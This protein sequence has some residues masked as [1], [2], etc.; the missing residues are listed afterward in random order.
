M[1][2]LIAAAGTGGHVY[3]G[4]AVGE[5]LLDLGIAQSEILYVGGDRMEATVYPEAG[6]P[7]LRVEMRGLQRSASTR[8]LSLPRVVWRARD[9]IAGAMT[10]RKV[11][12]ALALGG[13]ITV[14]TGLAAR[15][16]HLPLMV[17]EQ[18]AEAGLANRVV[19]RWAVRS[20]ASFPNTPG[21]SRAEWVGN[22][23][24]LSIAEFDRIELR[25][26]A[27]AY[28][29]LAPD[30]PTLGVFGGSLGAGA[31]N[32]AVVAMCDAWAGPPLQIVHVT[33]P[34]NL[35]GLVAR[36]SQADVRWLRIGFED[37]ME[38]F[39]AAADL[40]V[41]RAGGGIAELTATGTPAILVPGEFGARGHQA[42]NANFLTGSGAAVLL[43][44]ANLAAL[45]E[46]VASIIFDPGVISEMSEAARKIGRPDAARV[47][48]AAMVEVAA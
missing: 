31:I 12:V 25:P 9:L 37:R 33:G 21:L 30:L 20:F 41:G 47:I 34:S 16:T 13:Y 15:Q 35:D 1:S 26:E 43:P 18:N 5:A 10:E 8:N 39:Y 24:R 11:Q 29:S 6:F 22:P 4:L 48:A 40:V 28:Y 44:E 36:Y 19:S 7:Y 23:V 38:L 45:G 32:E 27:L 46:V 17:A 14:P 2:F 3:P 42:A